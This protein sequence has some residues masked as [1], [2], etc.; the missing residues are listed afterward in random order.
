MGW[1]RVMLKR[2]SQFL[3]SLLF[4]FDLGL[5]C[6]CWIGAYYLRFSEIVEPATKGIPP[7]RNYLLLLVP[8]VAVWGMSFQAFDL[9]RPRRMGTRLS[10]FL[11]VAKARE[12]TISHEKSPVQW[13]HPEAA[14]IAMNVAR[15]MSDQG[16]R[17]DIARRRAE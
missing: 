13:S 15:H 2:H 7:L 9:Y 5:I 12:E 17:P 6:A 14:L 1:D 16:S 10:E 4:C 3:K 8:I 11:D